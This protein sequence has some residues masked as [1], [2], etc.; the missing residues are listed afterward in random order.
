MVTI[1]GVEEN[2]AAARAGLLAGDILL[3]VNGHEIGDV[4]DY[5]FY[6]AVDKNL[7]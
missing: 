1:T 4:L 6:L 7:I 3:T 5:R 2:S